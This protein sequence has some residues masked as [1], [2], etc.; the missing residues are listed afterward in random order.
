MKSYR[1]S[2]EGKLSA[3]IWLAILIVAGVGAYEWVPLRIAV[4]ELEDYMVESAQRAHN[5]SPQQLKKNILIRAEE[6]QLPLDKDSIEVK[7]VAGRIQM[8][9]EYVLPVELPFYTYNWTVNHDVDRA[10]FII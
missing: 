7:R 5:A 8:T 9:A 1:Q 6:L 2:G 10:V 3:I 4:A